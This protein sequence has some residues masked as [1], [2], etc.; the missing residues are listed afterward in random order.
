M[1]RCACGCEFTMQL[2]SLFIHL[3][4]RLRKRM[5]G[6]LQNQSLLLWWI[7]LWGQKMCFLWAECGW[8]WEGKGECYLLPPYRECSLLSEEVLETSISSCH[9]S[10]H[11]IIDV[12]NIS[13]FKE[14]KLS[15]LTIRLNTNC[16]SLLTMTVPDN[17]LWNF[18][19]VSWE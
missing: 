11:Y 4:F 10:V 3:N 12:K 16:F 7:F 13:G 8:K 19:D 14:L 15:S 9:I 2:H 17:L 18:I 6:L 1:K 5:K